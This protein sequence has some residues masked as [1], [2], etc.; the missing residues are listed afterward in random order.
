M[1]LDSFLPVTQHRPTIGVDAIAVGMLD[2]VPE[3]RQQHR[4]VLEVEKRGWGQEL[5]H[6]SIMTRNG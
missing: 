3:Q 1:R 5:G 2:D 4:R 6:T